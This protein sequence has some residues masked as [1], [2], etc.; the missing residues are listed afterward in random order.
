[1]GYAEAESII[2]AP[3][4]AVWACLNDIGHTPEWVCGLE[5]AEMVTDGPYGLGSAYTDHNRLGPFPQPIAGRAFGGVVP[6]VTR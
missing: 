3:D 2:N 6:G 1:M 4:E 5:G